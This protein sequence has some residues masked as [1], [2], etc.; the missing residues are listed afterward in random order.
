[1]DLTLV[2]WHCW[3]ETE[4]LNIVSGS[5]WLA[6]TTHLSVSRKGRGKRRVGGREGRR[7][8]RGENRR[9]WKGEER[10]REEKSDGFE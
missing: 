8:G 5:M 9:R 7:E 3:F 2:V 6:R 10:R 1:M 4:R